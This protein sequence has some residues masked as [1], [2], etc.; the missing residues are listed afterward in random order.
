MK[1]LA[2]IAAFLI[3]LVGCATTDFIKNIHIGMTKEQIIVA[4]GSPTTWNRQTINGKT[5]E[6][7]NYNVFLGN[8][9]FVD[10]VL[11]GYSRR[12]AFGNLKYY[13]ATEVE[14]TI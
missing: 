14:K 13:S 10:G 3:C 7:I 4:C 1:S 12:D 9:D 11:V 2:I 6:S 5:Y 8:F